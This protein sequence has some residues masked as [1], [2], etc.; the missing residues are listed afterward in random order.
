MLWNLNLQT[1]KDHVASQNLK[2]FPTWLPGASFHLLYWRTRNLYFPMPSSLLVGWLG[3]AS[4]FWAANSSMGTNW[5]A[6]LCVLHITYFISRASLVAHMCHSIPLLSRGCVISCSRQLNRWEE[7]LFILISC[8]Y[9]RF[10]HS[11]GWRRSHTQKKLHLYL[12]HF[13][14]VLK[15]CM[16]ITKKDKKIYFKMP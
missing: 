14:L 5:W 16:K 2:D 8:G 3:N 6:T 7:E 13:Q 1:P 9:N 15:N 10:W 11:F 4:I 12:D